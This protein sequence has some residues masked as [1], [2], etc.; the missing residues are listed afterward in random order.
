MNLQLLSQGF[1]L[2][3]PSNTYQ[4]FRIERFTFGCCT[5][6]RI[7]RE[8][9]VDPSIGRFLIQPPH[10]SA[11]RNNF[12]IRMSMNFC[13]ISSRLFLY[14]I[15]FQWLLRSSSSRCG[16]NQPS[17]NTQ[18]HTFVVTY[19]IVTLRRYRFFFFSRFVSLCFCI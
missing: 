18:R 2:I 3:P 13:T 8:Q 10:D 19:L 17:I 12:N 15:I 11:T 16:S 14:S 9:F 1:S 4:N 5:L 6:N 7:K